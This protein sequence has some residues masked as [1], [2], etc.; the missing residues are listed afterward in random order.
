MLPIRVEGPPR[1]PYTRFGFS[2]HAIFRPYRAPGN[3]ISCTV[4]AGMSLR[5]AL[6]PPIRFAE[7]GSAWIVVIPPAMASG[8]CGS[9]GQNE[10]SA[11]TSAVTGFVASLPSDSA[12]VPGAAYTPR[13]EWSSISPGVT[14]LPV[15]S[16]TTASLGASTFAR[17]E[18]HTSELQSHSDLVCRLLL[19][20]KK[21]Q[22]H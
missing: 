10:C 16:T 1:R 11:H 20:K 3:F 15:P 22:A 12:S 5:I 17:S 8:I 2:P 4:R 21:K 14:Y 13:C 18:E 7:P 9:C 6:R 19:E